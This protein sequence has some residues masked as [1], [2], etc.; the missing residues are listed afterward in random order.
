MPFWLGGTFYG[1]YD[2]ISNDASIVEVLRGLLYSWFESMS[3]FTTTG[4]TLIDTTIS[5][6]CIN[7]AQ[8][9]DC[10][11]AQ[12]KSILLW[13]S[14]TQWLGGIGVIMLG[15]VS[16]THLTLPTILLV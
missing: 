13:R 16:Y 10:I 8:D 15:S 6:I 9:I 7:A 11:A 3:G 14:L 4:A 2:L 5:P 1:P 12:P